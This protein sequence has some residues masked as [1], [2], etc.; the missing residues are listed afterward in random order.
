MVIPLFETRQGVAA[1]DP[2]FLRGQALRMLDGHRLIPETARELSRL[3]R[4]RGVEAVV[5]G[6]VAVVLHGHVRTTVDVDV[7]ATP[8]LE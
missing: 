7:L 6:G 2:L 4:E 3:F 5:I 1:R 8:P